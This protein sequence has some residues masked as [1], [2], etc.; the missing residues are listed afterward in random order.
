MA[1]H[2]VAIESHLLNSRLSP[3]SKDRPSPPTLYNLDNQY[4]FFFYGFEIY[5]LLNSK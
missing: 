5:P 4:G 1:S 2:Y 3:F